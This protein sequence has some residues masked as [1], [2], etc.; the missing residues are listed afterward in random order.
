[1][2]IDKSFSQGYHIQAWVLAWMGRYDEAFESAD[3]AAKGWG[4]HRQL[5]V[6]RA[7]IAARR[8]NKSDALMQLSHLRE[9]Q[10]S[11]KYV[12]PFEYASIH[13]ALGDREEMYTALDLASRVRFYW[14]FVLLKVHPLFVHYHSEDR[15][16]ALLNKLGLD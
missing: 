13:A 10:R 14:W 16:K 15:F 5:T 8:G 7:I 1:M 4:D 12:H 6:V 2:E 3:N 9:S 11:G